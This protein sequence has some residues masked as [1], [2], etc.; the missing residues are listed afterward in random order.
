MCFN[1]N[2]VGHL[3]RDCAQQKAVRAKDKPTEP[4]ESKREPKIFTASLSKWRCGVTKADGLHEDLVGAQTT[5]HV[6]LLGMTRTAL[7]D[8]CLQVSI[9][10][11]QMLVDALQN[12]YDFNA[13]VDEIDL[14]R[15]KQVYDDSGNPMSF[16]GAV[17]LA[18]QVNKGTRHRIGLF[19]QAEDDDV[20]ALGRNALKKLG[21]SLTPHAQP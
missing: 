13:D 1:C 18:I 9:V 11:L 6:Q 3:R 12:G 2:E 10:P 5:A 8:T 4:A 15:S 20:I 19:V 16:K 14:D 7:L 21:L 17:R